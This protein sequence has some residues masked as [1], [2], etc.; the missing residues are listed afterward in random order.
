MSYIREAWSGLSRASKK[1][2]TDGE[3]PAAIA[4]D[5]GAAMVERYEELRS[6]VLGLGELVSARRG[7][8]LLV[9]R[10]MLAWMCA[11]SSCSTAPS[12]CPATSRT[13][14]ALS[15]SSEVVQIL[16]SMALSHY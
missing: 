10:G 11:W 5:A 12:D 4:S 8:A 7:W 3:S 2:A 16:V 6:Q 1:N 15:Q 9:R 14:H 13:P